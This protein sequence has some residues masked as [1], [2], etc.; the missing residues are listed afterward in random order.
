MNSCAKFESDTA[1]TILKSIYEKL[2]D[3][4]QLSNKYDPQGKFR[5]QF[6]ITNI[7]S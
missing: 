6:L 7:F 3:F 4:V 1:L 5:N 2:P